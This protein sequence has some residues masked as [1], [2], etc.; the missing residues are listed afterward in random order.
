MGKIVAFTI[1]SVDG[2]FAGPNGEIDWFKKEDDED[3]E[4]SSESS[5][6]SATLIFGHTTYTMMAGYWPTPEAIKNNPTVAGI[7]NNTPKIVFS[8]TL[9][10]V[11]DG[12]V[13]K[14]VQIFHEINREEIVKLKEEGEGDIAI[15]GSGSIV[16][17]F[18]NLGLIDEYGLMVNPIILGAGKYLF[19][20]VN[21]MN[22]KLFE[23]RTFRNGK[24]FLKYRPA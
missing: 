6:S 23:T 21:R 18:A 3:R 20:N 4:F 24:V 14:N 2:Y 11:E 13:W 15:L 16:Q 8:K 22:L 19:K 12:P 5:K 1:V 10:S 17:Q 7:M 9:K